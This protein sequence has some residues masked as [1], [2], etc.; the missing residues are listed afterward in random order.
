M[1]KK[2][3]RII[4]KKGFKELINIIFKRCKVYIESYIYKF[5]EDKYK[6]LSYK[7]NKK[8]L[9]IENYEIREAFK[10]NINILNDADKIINHEFNFL[11][12]NYLNIGKNIFWN[13]DYLHDF[14]WKNKYYK[15]IKAVD[16]S[17][18]ADVK[19]PWELSRMHQ[20]VILGQAYNI[21]NDEKYTKEFIAQ[22]NSW[23]K[24]NPYKMSVNWT[25]AME[26][27][28]RAVNIIT[29]LELFEESDLIT[30]NFKSLINDVLYKHG[31]FIYE[32]LEIVDG[33]KSNHYLADICGLFWLGIYFNEYNDETKKW[34]KFGY[35]QLEIEILNETNE[36]GT[37]YEGSTSYHKLVTEMF[38][39]SAIFA[40]KNGYYLS[41]DF[42]DRLKLMIGFLESISKSDYTIPLFGDNDDGRF[43]ILEN[44]YSNK[45]YSIKYLIALAKGYFCCKD[46]SLNENID[47]FKFIYGKTEFKNEDE[48]IRKNSYKYG[49]YYILK[50]ERIKMI[51]RCGELSFRGQGAHSHNDQLSFELYIDDNDIFI[52]PGSYVYTSNY[53][54]R[55]KFRST[56][57]HNTVLIDNAEQ[58]EIDSEILFALK[59]RTHSKNLLFNDCKF[60]GIHEGYKSTYGLTHKREINLTE[61]EINIIDE[62]LGENKKN[63]K[64]ILNLSPNVELKIIDNEIIINSYIHILTDLKFYVNESIMSKSYG[65]LN[66]NKQII[67]ET[68][69]N[70]FKTKIKI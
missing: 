49:G 30:K 58:N 53:K 31:C 38:L 27:S 59:E 47:S 51:I 67:F 7:T 25:C 60:I 68:S 69:L 13:K 11:G 65:V 44:Y 55:N 1:I 2:I 22:L 12:M 20:L 5:K 34:L 39:F 37:S 54:L 42:N 9:L 4:K 50:N 62:I 33:V 24:E 3:F 56:S 6:Y 63:K 46:I 70:K 19:L 61:N 14:S 48:F 45:K 18:K 16:K 28:I 26:V 66:K 40:K 15:K 21:S 32:N 35:N 29:A 17:Y 36:D 57:M 43:I 8:R 10:N 52:D 41:K 23:I 64:V